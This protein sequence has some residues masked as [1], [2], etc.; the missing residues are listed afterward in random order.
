MIE[1]GARLSLKDNIYATMQKNLKLQKQF[2]EQVEQTRA[3]VKGLGNAKA[4]P[5]MREC[6]TPL[7]Y[8][9]WVST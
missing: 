1:F 7:M 9:L 6:V 4:S 8:S 5:I 2:T 3:S